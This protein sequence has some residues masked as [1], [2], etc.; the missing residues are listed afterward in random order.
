VHQ[1]RRARLDAQ[2]TQELLEVCS[3]QNASV[4]RSIQAS[5]TLAS[6]VVRGA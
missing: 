6:C 5:Q 3:R 2:L 1:N 4:D